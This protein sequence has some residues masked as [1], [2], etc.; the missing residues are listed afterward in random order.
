[1]EKEKLIKILKGCGWGALAIVL[2]FALVLAIASPVAKHVINNKGEQILGRQ[3]HADLVVINPFWG[4]VTIKGFECKEQNGETNFVSFDRLYVRIAYPQLLAKRVNIRAIHL[5]GFEGQV[6]KTNDKL[7]FSDIIAR[8]AKPDTVPVDTTPS[9]WVVRLNDIRLNNSTLRY[10]DVINDKQ[11][12][13]EDVS[14]RVPGLY[15]DNTQTNAGLEFGLPTG[16]RVGIA[17]GYRMQVNRYAVR[18]NLYDVHADVALPLVQDYLNVT[19]LGARING[20]LHVDGSLENIMNIQLNGHLAMTGLDIRDSHRDEV[21]AMDELRMVINKGDLLTNTFILDTLSITGITGQYEVHEEWNTL[22]RLLK[23]NSEVSDQDSVVSRIETSS[24]DSKPLTWMAKKVKI[25]GHD[26]EYRDYSMSNNWK[27]AIKTLHVEGNNV[28]N[29]GRNSLKINATLS[30]D[31]QLKAD[32]TGATDLQKYNSRLDL[33]LRGV[34]MEDFDAL[35]RNY[36]GYPIESGVLLLDSH[37]EVTDGKI[38]GNNRIEIDHPEIGKRERRSKAPYKNIPVRTGFKA[39]TS[40]QNMIIV[41]VPVSG[42]ANNP[43]FNL[44]KV[45]SRALLKVFFGPLM[46][47]N[48]RNKSLSA[49]ELEQLEELFEEDSVL[50]GEDTVSQLPADVTMTASD[51]VGLSEVS[52]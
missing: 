43:K 37:M 30:S 48:D 28:A 18:L 52:Q 44:R 45:I 11:W 49:E 38:S 14:L 5:D 35:C 10:R 39:L 4:G 31:A 1:M 26:L 2:L 20:S 24:N 29:K 41:D 51:S 46:G 19:G 8:F 9:N 7:N 50:L 36:T 23:E 21:A 25:D 12:K 33:Q 16:G 34:H 42:D 47:I 3:L 32:F 27:Y 15:F 22:S 6:L 13:L 40:A 17:A